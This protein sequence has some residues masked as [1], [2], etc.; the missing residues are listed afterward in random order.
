MSLTE[1]DNRRIAEALGI[2]HEL[3][4]GIDLE[5]RVTAANKRVEEF[6]AENARL[7]SLVMTS[8]SL[9]GSH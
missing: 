8:I 9:P 2:K 7:R 1:E 4:K 5:E 6:E 3:R